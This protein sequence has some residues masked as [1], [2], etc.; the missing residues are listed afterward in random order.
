MLATNRPPDHTW[1]ISE[2]VSLYERRPELVQS[3][4]ND[5]LAADAEDAGIG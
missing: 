1:T 3:A 5:A 4:L 2:I